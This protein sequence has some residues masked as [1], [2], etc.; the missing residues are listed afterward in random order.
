[1][2]YDPGEHRQLVGD[3]W[4]ERSA[5]DAIEQ[6]AGDAIGAYRGPER[7]WPNAAED[8]EGEADEPFRNAYFGA[9]GVAWALDHLARRG[10]A[11]EFGEAREL[12]QRLHQD[13]LLAPELTSYEP[14]PAASLLF[15][16]S[17][18]LLAAEA[19]LGDGSQLTCL[20][21]VINGNAKHP[22]LELCWGSPGTMTAALALWR[23]SG[24]ER[25]RLAWIASAERLFSEWH[26]LVWTQ[27]L[28]GTRQQ[29]VGAGHGFAGTAFA[30]LS[31]RDLLG[32]R[33]EMLVERVR[34]VL[35]D[36]ASVEGSIAQWFPLIG[37]VTGRHPVQWCH[38][39]PGIVTSL[40]DLPPD[41]GT[42][43]LLQA[44]GELT[45]QAGALKKGFGLCHGTAGNAYAFLAL[46]AR[47][48]DELWLQR[49]RA[50][51]MDV[52]ADIEAHRLSRGRR[53]Y[54]LYTGDLGAAMLIHACLAGDHNFPF[55]DGALTAP[56][57]DR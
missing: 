32:D 3:T 50:F 45:W 2:L 51:A 17:G 14:A 23:A 31:G 38:G 25:W 40:A 4:N 35:I 55:L 42:D 54:S 11:P 29:Y 12:A 26:D 41:D 33:A 15:G 27:D 47:S 18:I 30:L 5:L 19:I 39:S 34:N 22:S 21:A 46:F 6:I 24:E 9:A 49:A 7:L 1:M 53:R 48:N 44:A 56:P 37:T 8:L 28:Y 43:R 16:E 57:H 13:F 20:Q 10:V 36:Q 52:I